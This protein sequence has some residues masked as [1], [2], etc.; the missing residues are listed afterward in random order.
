[1]GLSQDACNLLTHNAYPCIFWPAEVISTVGFEKDLDAL[2]VETGSDG[3]IR[4]AHQPF[5]EVGLQLLHTCCSMLDPLMLPVDEDFSSINCGIMIIQLDRSTFRCLAASIWQCSIN[6]VC[7]AMQNIKTQ[8]HWSALTLCSPWYKLLYT[9]MPWL[10]EAK[11]IRRG[12]QGARQVRHFA[13]CQH[14][15]HCIASL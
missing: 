7:L 15:R 1:M 14:A 12:M 5:L 11:R 2:Q 6:I 13:C 8:L 9:A 10:T 4:L 3:K